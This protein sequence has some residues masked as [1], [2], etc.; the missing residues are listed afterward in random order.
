MRRRRYET[1]VRSE[2]VDG[3]VYYE[4]EGARPVASEGYITRAYPHQW[5]VYFL[6]SP[7]H[8]SSGV[9]SLRANRRSPSPRGAS[10]LAT[11][12]SA[13][14]ASPIAAGTVLLV[15]YPGRPSIGS[16]AYTA[17]CSYFFARDTTARSAARASFGSNATTKPSS[18]Q[19]AANPKARQL[20]TGAG[21]RSAASSDS[22]RAFAA[23]FADA[24]AGSPIGLCA[25]SAKRRE[26]VTTGGTG[27][28]G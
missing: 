13:S 26:A 17:P 24:E 14:T 1:E 19:S 10:H 22:R 15:R 12:T 11:A 4:W 18:R 25:V 28:G 8:S 21:L 7:G 9:H 16:Y 3:G 2:S 6:A 20:A 5:V 23:R 27:A